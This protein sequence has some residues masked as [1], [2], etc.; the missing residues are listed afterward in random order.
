MNRELDKLELRGFL[1][2]PCLCHSPYVCLFTIECMYISLPN[3]IAEKFDVSICRMVY[4]QLE[5][6]IPRGSPY[7]NFVRI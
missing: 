6:R 1:L 5:V 4:M 3:H 2:L 7:V